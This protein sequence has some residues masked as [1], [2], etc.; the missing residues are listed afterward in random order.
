[1]TDRVE[2]KGEITWNNRKCV[3]L[4]L[5]NPEFAYVKHTC[6]KSET[7]YAFAERMNLSEYMI[8]EKNG[9]SYGARLSAGQSISI[10]T[11]FAKEVVLYIDK[12][13]YMPIV[14]MIYDDKG[15]FEKYEFRNLKVNPSTASNEWTTQCTSYGFQ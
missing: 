3:R 13:N 8:M 4:I 9:L 10:P 1:M 11:S 12:E 6:T 14:Q 2:V 5:K 7:L 15:L